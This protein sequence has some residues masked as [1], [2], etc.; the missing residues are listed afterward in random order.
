MEFV[1]DLKTAV[2]VILV[3]VALKIAAAKFNFTPVDQIANAIGGFLPAAARP[4]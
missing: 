1:P 2:Q 4:V 3:L